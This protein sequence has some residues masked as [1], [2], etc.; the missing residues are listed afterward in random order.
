MGREDDNGKCFGCVKRLNQSNVGIIHS[1]TSVKFDS[2]IGLEILMG[3]TLVRPG[4][5]C[6]TPTRI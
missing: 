4:E 1:L 2:N 6:A 3:D 5:P